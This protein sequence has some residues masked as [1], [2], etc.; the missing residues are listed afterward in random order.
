MRF[1]YL[2]FKETN[3]SFVEKKREKGNNKVNKFQEGLI[4]NFPLSNP[5]LTT[6]K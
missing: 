4:G 5:L 6:T 3:Y 1:Y 2:S